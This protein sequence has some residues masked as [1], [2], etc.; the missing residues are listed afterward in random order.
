[1]EEFFD[2]L[3]ERGIVFKEGLLFI[4][5][6]SKGLIKAINRKFKDYALIQRCLWHKR[7][8]V[9]SHL[10]KGQ[11]VVWRKKLRTAYDK[12]THSEAEAALNKLTRELN[13]INPTAAGSLKEGMS[14][15]LTLHKLGLNQILRRSFSTTN[16]I[17][18]ILA[19]VEQYTQRVDRWRNGAHIQRWVASGLLEVEPRLKRVYGWRH[20]H[21]LRNRIKEEMERRRKEHLGIEEEQELIQVGA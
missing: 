2:N 15:T 19:Q 8:N 3:I 4:V 13:E 5:D 6:G 1:M 7:E 20:F 9:V 18:S 21:S 10:G 17:E 14:D 11:Q 12:P 16:C